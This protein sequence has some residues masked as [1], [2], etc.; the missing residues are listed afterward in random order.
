ML[1][2]FSQFPWLA[3]CQDSDDEG[4]LGSPEDC[5]K[6]TAREASTRPECSVVDFAALIFT[7]R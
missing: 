6:N 7:K 5:V 4:E 2:H 3:P 1:S